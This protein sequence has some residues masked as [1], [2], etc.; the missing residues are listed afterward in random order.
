[1]SHG[2]QGWNSGDECVMP[3]ARNPQIAPIFHSGDAACLLPLGLMADELRYEFGCRMGMLARPFCT[4][5]FLGRSV[6]PRVP[7]GGLATKSAPGLTYMPTGAQ[8][9]VARRSAGGAWSRH[10]EAE[11]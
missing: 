1:M 10:A 6:A 9:G 4:G 5:D 7:E 3:A 2:H 8:K 11:S